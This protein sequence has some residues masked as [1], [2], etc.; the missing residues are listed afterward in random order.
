[1]HHLRLSWAA[2]N[3]PLP[4]EGRARS[5]SNGELC[6]CE[7][8]VGFNDQLIRLLLVNCI[9]LAFKRSSIVCLESESSGSGAE[10][11]GI[12]YSACDDDSVYELRKI[13][14][15]GFSTDDLELDF[16]LDGRP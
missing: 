10:K 16:W 5:A 4:T 13:F 7:L 12:L 9:F 1:M 15:F 3:G 14:G 2:V 6:I 8:Q 11:N